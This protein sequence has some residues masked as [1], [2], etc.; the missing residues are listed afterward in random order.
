[1]K[2]YLLP[3]TGNFY[4]ANLHVHTDV[5]DGAM[6]PEETKRVYQEHG[7]SV[8]AFTDHE[9]MVPHPELTDENF[10]AITSTEIIVNTRYDCDFGYVKTYHLNIFSPDEGK[11]AF[12]T[13]DRERLWLNHSLAYITPEQEKLQYDRVYSVECVNDII[14]R[15][16]SEN[17]LVSYNHP[18]WS[19]QDYS[20]YIDLK[21]LWGVEVY[22][23]GCAK[24]GYF[25]SEKPFDD[26]LR[27]GERVFPLATDDTHKVSDCFGGFVMIGAEKLG[28]DEIFG[29]LREGSFYASTGP[30]FSE[31][32]IDD[33]ILTVKCSPVSL[34]CVSTDC[35]YMYF[36]RANEELISEAN[37]DIR[38]FLRLKDDGIKE[39]QYI[40]V[41]ALDDKGNKA[42]SRAYFMDELTNN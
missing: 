21:G 41:T 8:V 29:A 12:N 16:N 40:R 27:C 20:D 19:L 31:I 9:V 30:T 1:M 36:D 33:G 6:T 35:R 17:C 3:S 5:S 2:K 10:L 42:Y 4:K 11:N 13:F 7:Y 32:S 24:S 18:V 25:D 26:L 22:N 38:G 37:F 15:A 14:R 34:I 23:S 28:Y 39:H